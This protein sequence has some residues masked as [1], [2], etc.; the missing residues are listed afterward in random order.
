MPD[1]ATKVA[2]GPPTNKP[3]RPRRPR[4]RRARRRS[5][6]SCAVRVRSGS[7]FVVASEAEALDRFQEIRPLISRLDAAFWKYTQV[8]DIEIRL[9]VAEDGYNHLRVAVDEANTALSKMPDR[10]Q[11]QFRGKAAVRGTA[12][13]LRR[14]HKS[15]RR[16]IPRGRVLR[17]QQPQAGL[18]EE[19]AKGYTAKWADF[20]KAAPQVMQSLEKAKDEHRKLQD[21]PAVKEALAAIHRSTRAEGAAQPRE[22]TSEPDRHH[23]ESPGRNTHQR[24]TFRRK[25]E[26]RRAAQ[27]R[28]SD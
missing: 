14:S 21:D 6:S 28:I 15:A 18:K 12:I 13:V 11:G 10:R 2:A 9:A 17:A 3:G 7:H 23:Q 16:P 22:K 1:A 27:L 24:H 5:S 8:L 25:R 19:L 20:L 26:R 4:S